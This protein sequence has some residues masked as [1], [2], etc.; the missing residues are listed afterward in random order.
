MN[1]GVIPTSG[2]R[3]VNFMLAPSLPTGTMLG[4]Q[5]TTNG[6]NGMR[7]SNSAPIVVR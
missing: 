4:L 1:L 6:P 7:R 2:V 5:A 3:S